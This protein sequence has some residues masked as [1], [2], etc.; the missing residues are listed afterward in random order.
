MPLNISGSVVTALK[1]A[2]RVVVVT[3][4][5]ISAESGIPTFRGSEGLWRNFKAEDLATPQAFQRD[6]R[7]VWEWYEWRRELCAR[8]EPNPAHAVVAAME[9]FYHH[10]TLVTQNVDGLHARAGSRRMVEIHGSIWRAQCTQCGEMVDLPPEVVE[11]PEIAGDEPPALELPRKHEHC[12]GL[13]RPGVVW[14]GENYDAETLQS[15]FA[16]VEE[17]Q[18]L[19]VIGTSG[20]V[21]LPTDLAAQARQ[22]GATV[23]E[24]N[25]E[26][27]PLSRLAHERLEGRAGEILPELW[28]RAQ[29]TYLADE[30]DAR[31]MQKQARLLVGIAGPPGAGKSV[32]A[33]E[34]S[35]EFRNNAVY[36]S[37]DGF[38][39]N[40]ARLEALGMRD[41]KGAP[42]TF[43]RLAFELAVKELQ[44]SEQEIKLPQYSRDSHEPIPEAFTVYPDTPIVI[45]EGNYLFHWP[46]IRDALD[47]RIYLDCDPALA[48]ASLVARHCEGGCTETEAWQKVRSNDDPNRALVE[49]SRSAAQ[50]VV[51]R[52]RIGWTVARA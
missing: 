39:F 8:A 40:N 25:T 3:G 11:T 35:R 34:L 42:E 26:R 27:T 36:V 47:L 15:V 43:D 33:R 31:A 1:R 9:R 13:L 30:I 52:D 48:A 7:T 50:I 5:G 16:A 41:R 32:L 4:A 19:L 38:H 44:T 10:F 37:M 28:R 21:S 45:L 29:L 24:I 22:A 17:A 18:L 51:R 23:V 20:G 46:E 12:G 2:N 6:P 14:F 49:A